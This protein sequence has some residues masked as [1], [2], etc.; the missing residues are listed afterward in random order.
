MCKLSLVIFALCLFKT[1]NAACLAPYREPS[2]YI[3]TCG[4]SEIISGSVTCPNSCA[5]FCSCTGTSTLCSC[6][7]P[8]CTCFKDTAKV[9]GTCQPQS[10]MCSC[11][12]NLDLGCNCEKKKSFVYFPEVEYPI[13]ILEMNPFFFSTCFYP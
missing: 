12:K 6:G 1:L 11:L 2:V 8:D 13:S 9:C 3:P 4:F 10:P 7:A 5:N